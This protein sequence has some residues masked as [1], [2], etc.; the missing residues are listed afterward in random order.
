MQKLFWIDAVKALCMISVYLVH[1]E[2]YYSVEDVHYNYWLTPFYVN[3]FF[4]I[5]GYLF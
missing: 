2:V 5:S 3:A 4:F 1:S